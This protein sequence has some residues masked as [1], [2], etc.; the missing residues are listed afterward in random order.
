MHRY[1]CTHTHPQSLEVPWWWAMEVIEAKKCIDSFL[2][3]F[4]CMASFLNSTCGHCLFCLKFKFKQCTQSHTNQLY[5]GQ[6]EWTHQESYPRQLWQSLWRNEKWINH[7]LDAFITKWTSP[8]LERR[9]GHNSSPGIDSSELHW[10]SP[11]SVTARTCGV[12]D[13]QHTLKVYK[14]EFSQ[15]KQIN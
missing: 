2:Y 8:K 1:T 14:P 5:F 13:S 4:V 12:L 6:F 7:Y 10:P 11:L 9:K 15:M 3:T